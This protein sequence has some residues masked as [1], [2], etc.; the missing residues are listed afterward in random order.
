MS[1]TRQTSEHV[2][3]RVVTTA[4]IVT[5]GAIAVTATSSYILDPM[6][7]DFGVTSDQATML[8]FVPDLATIV[9]VFV[10]GVLGDRIGR[11]RT[12]TWGSF[13]YLVGAIITAV[14]P[15]MY[16]AI[17]GMALLGAGASTM[18]IVGMALLGA[19]LTGT[20][21]RARAFGTLGVVSPA[22][23]LV[24][25]V[26]AG[27]FVTWSS[28]RMVTILWIVLGLVALLIVRRLLPADPGNPDAGEFVTPVLAGIVLVLA[29]QVF[30]KFSDYGMSLETWVFIAL[31]IGFAALLW[32][33][34]RHIAN[35][36]LSFGPLKAHRAV[37]LLV[38]TLLI[39]L[40]ALWYTTYLAFEYIFGLTPV[41]IAVI[42]LPAQVAGM[43][44]AK[45]VPRFV[46]TR[47][48]RRAA[49]GSLFV[50]AISELLFM[51][52][53]TESMWLM[54]GLMCLYACASTAVTVVM[55]NA[56]MDAVPTSE[57]GTMAAYRAAFSRMGSALA[58][59]VVATLVI[60]TYH[61]SL[62]N[63]ATQ[64][65]MSTT[66]TDAI[67]ASL[68]EEGTPPMSQQPVGQQPMD[69]TTLEVSALQ[70]Q[71]MIDSLRTKALFGA[72]ICLVSAALITVALRRRPEDEGEESDQKVSAA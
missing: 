58:S 48:I 51:F 32:I 60:G 29:T 28:W 47:G 69:S 35:P 63:E 68:I 11:R 21:D 6:A 43:V 10:A 59:L 7:N 72:G 38:V 23:Y 15:N 3:G 64:A 31:T 25:P 27:F 46:I 44:G 39:A 26:I 41:Q 62:D 13:A 66:S 34:H 18:V 42:L 49:L 8:K 30:S 37:L 5:A 22:V 12:I 65:G 55:S 33:V 1:T 14:S 2:I 52:V 9:V 71:A 17:A 67:A 24:A 16:V 70:K 4:C 36:T 40:A 53:G 57:S 56:V 19:S 45:I 20:D 61:V 54:A 50:L